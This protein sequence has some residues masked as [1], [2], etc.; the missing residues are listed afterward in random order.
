VAAHPVRDRHEQSAAFNPQKAR[1]TLLRGTR[2]I[3]GEN[4]M[5]VLI[6]APPTTHIGDVSDARVKT[7]DS[8]V[9][10]T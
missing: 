8:L 4:Q 9:F 6:V 3:Q 2:A 5:T 10:A 7:E 1:G